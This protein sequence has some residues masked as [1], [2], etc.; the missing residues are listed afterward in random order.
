MK[1]KTI[2]NTVSVAAVP[3]LLILLS[4]ILIFNPDAA[5]ALVGKLLG[6]VL[7]AVGAVLA[8][9]AGTAEFD[10]LRKAIPAALVLLLGIWL[11]KNPLR[12]AAGIG[13]IAGVLLIVRGIQAL[14]DGIDWKFGMPT[15]IV[16]IAAGLVLL[17]VPMT[18]SRVVMVLIGIVILA[19][20]VWELLA[21]LGIYKPLR[22]PDESKIIDAL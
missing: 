10:K 5:S 17:S 4:L 22:E 18:T 3:V 12:L 16:M 19:L 20:A 6:W 13:R 11:L 21:R 2:M 14:S 9:R 15:E 8:F 1:R 7:V